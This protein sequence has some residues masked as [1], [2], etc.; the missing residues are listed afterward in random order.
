MLIC[1][2]L[3]QVEIAN[4]LTREHVEGMQLFRGCRFALFT[5]PVYEDSA[6]NKHAISD[7]EA[8]ESHLFIQTC[9]YLSPGMAHFA[10][11]HNRTDYACLYA[12]KWTRIP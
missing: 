6:D 5:R 11:K 12:S 2:Y 3:T 8:S 9:V 4:H 10:L 1:V 7:R